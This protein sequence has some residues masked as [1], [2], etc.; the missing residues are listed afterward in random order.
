MASKKLLSIKR[1]PLSKARKRSILSSVLKK[2]VNDSIDSR[3]K[4]VQSVPKLK[5]VS[6]FKAQNPFLQKIPKAKK[7]SSTLKVSRLKL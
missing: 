3:I 1:I 7:L 6:P 4:S 2:S 5:Q